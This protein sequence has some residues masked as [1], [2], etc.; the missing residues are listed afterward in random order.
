MDETSNSVRPL[1][2]SVREEVTKDCSFE[3]HGVAQAEK[4]NQS[5][6]EYLR[7]GLNLSAC[8]VRKS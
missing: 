6:Y 7:A 2:G 8:F 1:A 4:G 5:D 3:A